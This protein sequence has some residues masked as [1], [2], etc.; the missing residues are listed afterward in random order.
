MDKKILLVAA[1]GFALWALSRPAGGLTMRTKQTAAG[2]LTYETPTTVAE[3]LARV[4]AGLTSPA[5]PAAP[6]TDTYA[7]AAAEVVRRG[8][9]FTLDP[10]QRAVAIDPDAPLRWWATAKAQTPEVD[11]YLAAPVYDVA[12]NIGEDIFA[13][14]RYG[15]G[16]GP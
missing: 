8:G 14:I 9:L 12:Q 10:L 11:A 5:R 15:E 1:A 4:V 16:F 6:R 3:R 2:P 13:G 7:G